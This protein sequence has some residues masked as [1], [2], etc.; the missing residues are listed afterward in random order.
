MKN[1]F[2]FFS[3]LWTRYRPVFDG[4]NSSLIL[5]EDANPQVYLVDDYGGEI[6]IS[7]P[8]TAGDLYRYV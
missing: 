4:N 3:F 1:D 2:N 8:I 7:E 5:T 6:L